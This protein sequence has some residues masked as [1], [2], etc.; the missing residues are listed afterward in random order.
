MTHPT[1]KIL[2][3][4]C[5]LGQ[6]VRYDGR[7]KPFFHPAIDR[8]RSEGRL[9]AICPEMAGGMPVPRPPAEIEDRASGFDVLEGRARVLEVTG[10]DV[11]AQF[12]AGAER[13]LAFARANACT[14]ALLI[15]GS[16]SCGSVA[17]YDG[18]FSGVKHAGN[19]VTAALLEK[20]G[21][22]VFSPAD[23]DRLDVLTR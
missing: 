21:I 4:A 23:I 17:I 18:S 8:W 16:P 7:G 1:S 22:A 13:A 6:P 14:Y 15:D 12:I 3:S 11:T 20:A 19:G 9:V 5:L 2:I 10:G